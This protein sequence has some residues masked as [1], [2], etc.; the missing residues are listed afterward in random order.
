MAA[1]V[2]D[3][4]EEIERMLEPGRLRM[5][6]RING[7]R[8]VLVRVRPTA[9]QRVADTLDVEGLGRCDLVQGDFEARVAVVLA[10]RHKVEA[11]VRRERAKLAGCEA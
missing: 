5:R 2:I 9:N 4:L 11:F 6:R 7:R 3:T 1:R 8:Y 10:P